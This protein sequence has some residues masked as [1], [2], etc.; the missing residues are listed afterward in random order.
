[1]TPTRGGFCR[2]LMEDAGEWSCQRR[3]GPERMAG[4]F[5]RFFAVSLRPT[6]DELK[7]LL[8]QAGFGEVSEAGHLPG[9]MRGVHY[10]SP[11]GGY[12]IRYLKDQ[13]EGARVHTVLHETYEI[14]HETLC[15]LHAASPPPRIVCVEANRFAAAVLLQPDAF[16][17]FAKASGYDVLALQKQYGCSYATATLRLAEVMRR[18]PLMAVLYEREEKGEIAGWTRQPPPSKLMASVVVRTPGF[19]MRDGPLLCGERGGRP[20]KAKSVSPGSL[21]HRVLLSGSAAYAER[22]PGRNGNGAG[23]SDLAVAARPVLWSGR[24]AKI[25]LVAVPYR[26]RAVLSPQ[27]AH[28]SFERVDDGHLLRPIDAGASDG[29]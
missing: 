13:P 23:P 29:R 4:E 16:A 6:M 10:T 14:I 9:G 26:D 17:L 7:A 28:D 3:F 11:H 25:A 24:L 22:R 12:D 8:V 18:Q 27:L 19:G 5:V 20:R 21:A 15:D 2:K 1:M